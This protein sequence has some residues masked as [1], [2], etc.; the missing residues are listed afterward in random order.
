MMRK[1]KMSYIFFEAPKP[2]A[3]GGPPPPPPPP[4]PSG[5]FDDITS[6]ATSEKSGVGALFADINKGDDVTKGK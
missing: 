4:P 6:G 5:L 3:A 1:S 2:G